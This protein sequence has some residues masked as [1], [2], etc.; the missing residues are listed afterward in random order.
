[1]IDRVDS[2]HARRLKSKHPTQRWLYWPRSPPAEEVAVR[3]LGAACAAGSAHGCTQLQ[4][5]TMVE[6]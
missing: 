4:V 1:M 3:Q 5:A 2:L 6:L